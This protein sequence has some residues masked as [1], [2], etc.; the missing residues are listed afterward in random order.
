MTDTLV[1]GQTICAVRGTQPL[2]STPQAVPL[3][4][5]KGQVA[6]RANV[7]SGPDDVQR[8]GIG[9]SK[10]IGVQ[11]E[12]LDQTYGLWH[13]VRD[14]SVFPLILRQKFQ[15]RARGLEIAHGIQSESSPHRIAPKEPTESGPVIEPGHVVAGDQ[16][17]ARER[18]VHQ[19][20]H[21]ADARPVVRG[22]QI[23][24]GESE[25]NR[26]VK[27]VLVILPRFLLELR[28]LGQQLLVEVA[29]PAF[30]LRTRPP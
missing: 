7:V 22:L 27:I 16:S 21:L 4:A 8:R 9:R 30:A 24:V 1:P 12:P 29:R 15:R 3:G 2:I 23:T 28:V 19:S 26:T 14:T 10:A 6:T 20:L 25:R 18:F 17:L 11:L 13:L 5:R